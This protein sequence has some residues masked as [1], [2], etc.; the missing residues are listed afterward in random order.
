MTGRRRR[1]VLVAPNNRFDYVDLHRAEES[2]GDWEEDG[3]DGE[4]SDILT[5][6]TSDP[7]KLHLDA[8]KMGLRTSVAGLRR[9][10]TYEELRSSR[11]GIRIKLLEQTISVMQSRAVAEVV[12]EGVRL[13]YSGRAMARS[14]SMLGRRGGAEGE[15]GVECQQEQ[16][17]QRRL[18]PS[19][20]D[21]STRPSQSE[22][23]PRGSGMEPRQGRWRPSQS[24]MMPSQSDLSPRGSE[25]EPSQGRSRPSQSDLSPRESET[26]P[27]QGRS[28]PSQSHLSLR[29]SEARPSQNDL[30][31]RGSETEPSQG[32]SRPSQSHLSPR[33]SEAGPSQSGMSSRGMHMGPSQ[34]MS[35]HLFN[36]EAGSDLGS[37]MAAL[38]ICLEGG[39]MESIQD[40]FAPELYRSPPLEAAVPDPWEESQSSPRLLLD[41]APPQRGRGYMGGGFR[42]AP[43]SS[44]PGQVPG[45]GRLSGTGGAADN[46]LGSATSPRRAG[47]VSSVAVTQSQPPYQLQNS[48]AVNHVRTQ[49]RL[50]VPTAHSYRYDPSPPPLPVP[51]FKPAA[52][53]IILYPGNFR[54]KVIPTSE[55]RVG[56]ALRGAGRGL[57][58][59]KGVP[60]LSMILTSEER[61]GD[62]PTGTGG[63]LCP[64]KGGLSTGFGQDRG[65]LSPL[66]ATPTAW[67][68]PPGGRGLSPL[69]GPP[70]SQGGAGLGQ[71]RGA[72]LSLLRR[73]QPPSMAQ[74]G[75]PVYP[76][77]PSLGQAGGLAGTPRSIRQ[78][79]SHPPASHIVSSYS[80]GSLDHLGHA[81]SSTTTI[82]PTPP[83]GHP[84]LRKSKTSPLLLQPS[85]HQQVQQQHITR[86]ISESK[87]QQTATVGADVTTAGLMSTESSVVF[88]KKASR[89]TLPLLV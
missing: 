1:G 4:S 7:S 75:G 45:L 3:H 27:S 65:G 80:T 40:P 43:P 42:C 26:E 85:H 54:L 61:G 46:G 28:R 10:D 19:Q 2:G 32:R 5:P 13:L 29:G 20:S 71:M 18:R 57:S 83:M 64:I 22:L 81:T 52:E 23:S 39:A 15:E 49:A 77:P 66:M 89:G 9:F 53:A 56:D 34:D 69:R 62:A 30:S 86:I 25:T 8:L 68:P 58:P 79:V 84:M 50:N 36:L 17:E 14:Q 70:P 21:R 44:G 12:A 87:Q 74:G 55:E 82:G 31:P 11:S 51:A 76:A 73:I 59:M 48:F 72:P 41:K 60:R 24:N 16:Q 47:G 78:L 37:A 6:P 63:G 33:E 88:K 38:K 67:E 35:D